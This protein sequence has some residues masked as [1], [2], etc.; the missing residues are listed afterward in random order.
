MPRYMK[1]SDV[2]AMTYAEL[3]RWWEVDFDVL[4]TTA[5]AEATGDVDATVSAALHSDDWLEQWAD[6]LYAAAGELASSVERIT[7]TRDERLAKV[8]RQAGV[9]HQRMGQVNG[10]LK[11][12][13]GDQG[14][15]MLAPHLKDTRLIALSILA[16]HHQ[17]ESARLRAEELARRGL[18]LE[19]PMYEVS[20]RDGLE[21]IEDA[22]RHQLIKAPVSPRVRALQAAAPHKITSVVAGDV[23]H[24]Q[25]RCDDLRHPLLLR[26]WAAALEHLRDR[27]CALAGIP[28]EF[29]TSLATLDFRELRAMRGEQ[30]WDI[31]NRRRFIR[32]LAQRWRECAMHIRQLGRVWGCDQ[33]CDS[34]C[35]I[36]RRP[37]HNSSPAW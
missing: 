32:A 33:G 31:I 35:R 34:R 10:L 30:A 7:Y 12:R 6:A 9:V 2:R 26:S 20:Y 11:E 16:K 18:P 21:A 22:V 14:W 8:K 37:A 27:H 5:I 19:P 25:E 28:P 13:R 1:I 29:T 36:Q 17:E 15:D 3:E 23:T 24:Q 4:V